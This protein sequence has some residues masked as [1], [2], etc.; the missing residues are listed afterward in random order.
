MLVIGGE[1]GHGAPSAVVDLSLDVEVEVAR[2]LRIGVPIHFGAE[3]VVELSGHALHGGEGVRGEVVGDRAAGPGQ[4]DGVGKLAFHLS[5]EM[6]LHAPGT[7]VGDRYVVTAAEGKGVI[8]ALR[9]R[10]RHSGNGRA[11]GVGQVVGDRMFISDDGVREGVSLAGRGRNESEYGPA[12]G[13]R[14]GDS[15]VGGVGAV[16][17][18]PDAV[19]IDRARSETGVVVGD[20]V[21]GERSNL[22]PGSEV[23]AALQAEGRFVVRGVGPANRNLARGNRSRGNDRRRGGRGTRARDQVFPP[24]AGRLVRRFFPNIGEIPAHESRLRLQGGLRNDAAARDLHRVR[25]GHVVSGA[26]EVVRGSGH[27]HSD[28]SA[29]GA[30]EIDLGGVAFGVAVGDRVRARGHDSHEPAGRHI[31]GDV[32]GGVAVED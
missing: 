2:G 14:R 29:R 16:V 3:N 15:G 10:S 27:Q 5:V 22:S 12:A 17:L 1:R 7:V 11:A 26:I 28:Q 30:V 18:R 25:P 8:S 31:S 24:V 13:R 9:Q 6:D 21:R 19:V 4:I 20:R 23:R 32:S